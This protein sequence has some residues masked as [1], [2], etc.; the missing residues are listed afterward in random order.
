MALATRR[1]RSR[2]RPIQHVAGKFTENAKPMSTASRVNSALEPVVYSCFG[3]IE[4][5][6]HRAERAQ[7]T[8]L[9]CSGMLCVD[10]K[11]EASKKFVFISPVG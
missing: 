9:R 8:R 4:R 1:H 11:N 2:V 7:L 5:G 6:A 3:E 10:P